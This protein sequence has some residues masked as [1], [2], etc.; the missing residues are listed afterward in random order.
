VGSICNPIFGQNS[1][2]IEPP[3]PFV[4]EAAASSIPLSQLFYDF[5]GRFLQIR[6]CFAKLSNLNSVQFLA[7][8][9]IVDSWFR[10]VRPPILHE[11]YD[12]RRS[13]CPSLFD[14]VSSGLLHCSV[15]V[16]RVYMSWRS[17]LSYRVVRV[18]SRCSVT[19]P[20]SQLCSSDSSDL[21][22]GLLR[23]AR[24]LQ[25]EPNLC[26]ARPL[27]VELY[28]H[29]ARPLARPVLVCTT[30]L[31]SFSDSHDLQVE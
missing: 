27:Q 10:R 28:F 15:D 18:L 14:L 9:W 8:D 25:V 31:L 6:N 19:R 13:S 7:E 17:M 12:D 30:S 16:G 21:L 3:A 24:P 11:L 2:V 5:G 1:S 22:V 29:H 4:L 23:F 20:T 26:L